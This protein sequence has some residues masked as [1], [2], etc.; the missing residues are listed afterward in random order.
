[1]TSCT[2]S[3]RNLVVDLVLQ[4]PIGSSESLVGSRFSKSHGILR[5]F[6][7]LPPNTTTNT[8]FE[9]LPGLQVSNIRR[10]C[11]AVVEDGIRIDA[12]MDFTDFTRNTVLSKLLVD[13][14]TDVSNPTYWAG[15]SQLG[16]KDASVIMLSKWHLSEPFEGRGF[17]SQDQNITWNSKNTARHGVTQSKESWHVNQPSLTIPVSKKVEQE[18]IL[19][20]SSCPRVFSRGPYFVSRSSSDIGRPIGQLVSLRNWDKRLSIKQIKPNHSK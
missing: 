9:S 18:G 1:M 8:V 12:K 7:N 4:Q 17:S 14:K 5:Y 11:P 13:H 2:A 16:T 20:H 3:R 10:M 6:E 15:L 19:S